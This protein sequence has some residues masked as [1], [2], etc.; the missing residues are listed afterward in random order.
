MGNVAGLGDEIAVRTRWFT[1]EL[2]VALDGAQVKEAALI[3]G[4]IAPS[5]VVAR[6]WGNR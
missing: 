1:L 3:D 4:G 2:D 5:R 6:A